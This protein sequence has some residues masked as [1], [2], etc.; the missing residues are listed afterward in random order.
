VSIFSGYNILIYSLMFADFSSPKTWETLL[1]TRTYRGVNRNFLI[2]E[3][4]SAEQQAEGPS[5]LH[6]LSQEPQ[7][8]ELVRKLP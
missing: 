2:L 6:R 3:F 5:Q 4:E 7:D 8:S 1:T